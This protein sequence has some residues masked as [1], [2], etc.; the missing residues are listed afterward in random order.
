MFREKE[1]IIFEELAQNP[2]PLALQAATRTTCPL[3]KWRTKNCTEQPP[4]FYFIFSCSVERWPNGIGIVIKRRRRQLG[5]DGKRCFPDCNDG[6]DYP[7]LRWVLEAP[8]SK[9]FILT[10]F[11]LF[12][13]VDNLRVRLPRKR[14]R[15]DMTAGS[16]VENQALDSRVNGSC[17]PAFQALWVFV[18][19]GYL[20]LS[21]H[22]IKTNSHYAIQ[23]R[24]TSSLS[25]LEVCSN[26]LN[27][28][29]S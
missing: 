7:Y 14:K 19:V 13:T 22:H 25:S 23:A 27:S 6:N 4:P 26:F 16:M 18:L 24:K 5:W 20:Q 21:L 15:R 3:S 1:K 17:L 12:L 2:G 8:I 29:F 11:G 10:R 9:K 28:V